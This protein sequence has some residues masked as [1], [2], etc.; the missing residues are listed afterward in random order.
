MKNL[1]HNPLLMIPG[2][3]NV[4]DD[5][6]EIVSKSVVPHRSLEFSK[7]LERTYE[8]LK[9]VFQ[10]KDDVYI[11]TSSGTGAM[12]AAIDNIINSGDKVLCLVN[13]IFSMRW[14]DIAR[15]KGA[16][17]F[18]IEVP[19]GCAV[20]PKV[21]REFLSNNSDIKIVTMAHSETSTGVVNNIKALC[22]IVKEYGAI[23][24][25][26]GISSVGVMECKK[27][28]W[29]IDILI[30]ASQKGFMLPPGLSFLS[31]SMRAWDLYNK[32]VY[33]NEYFDWKRYD[34]AM[35]Y[36]TVPYTP[37]VNLICALN[38]LLAE[39]KNEG[40][41]NIISK[42]A[43]YAEILRAGLR[44]MGLELL[45]NNDEISSSAVAAVYSPKGI[46]SN[47]IIEIM[48]NE[49]NIII[50]NGQGNLKDK[51][52]RIGTIGDIGEYE[53]NYTLNAL[54]E[55]LKKIC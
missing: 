44:N 39:Y 54:S 6:M 28:E 55:T 46:I 9:Y 53:I 41:E 40:L 26:D 52:F 33:H 10:T 7:T 5:I 19:Y 18:L 48:K 43:K 25:V 50:A 4:R 1:R 17:V 31:V 35:E 42:R 16:Q 47:E 8:N 22:K 34:Y 20:E 38:V 11:L 36:N 12:C 14:A 30:S 45:A 27:D 3:V 13:G 23:S 32:C 51:I 2:P 37:A 24:V 21:L 29:D 49:H 15:A